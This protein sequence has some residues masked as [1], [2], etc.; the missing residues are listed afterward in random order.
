LGQRQAGLTA[1][2]VVLL[3]L[4]HLI[5]RPAVMP[6]SSL[7]GADRPSMRGAMLKSLLVR[8]P[9]TMV[10]EIDAIAAA[11]LDQPD[12]STMIRDCLPESHIA[13]RAPAKKGG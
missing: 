2:R 5:W 4:A 11:R 3:E 10:G 12:R 7:L 1:D 8:L 9:E 6:A 13:R